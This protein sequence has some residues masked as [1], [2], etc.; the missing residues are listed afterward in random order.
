MI[1][2]VRTGGNFEQHLLSAWCSKH[3]RQWHRRSEAWHISSGEI[4]NLRHSISIS[5]TRSCRI[6]S[7]VESILN[8]QLALL[9]ICIRKFRNPPK[10]AFRP[11][12]GRSSYVRCRNCR[13]PPRGLVPIWSMSF[14]EEGH[15]RCTE[16]GLEHS[17][18]F[19][20]KSLSMRARCLR[21]GKEATLINRARLF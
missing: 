4:H 7:R 16:G 9:E 20:S 5:P 10:F 1:Y 21:R 14:A 12:T 3:S 13:W 17:L 15:F 2:V 18:E 11:E 6:V 8:H 19:H